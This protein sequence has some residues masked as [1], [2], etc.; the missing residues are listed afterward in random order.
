MTRPQRVTF[1][2]LIA[3]MLVAVASA[4]AGSPGTA[5]AATRSAS[6]VIDKS[7]TFQVR[8]VNRSALACP[9]DGAAYQVTGHLT[10][11][12]SKLG[13]QAA[14][15]TGSV[16]LYLHGA[17]F[18]E[19]FWRLSAV[20]RYDY[21][22]A[23]ARAGHVS[24][25]IDQLG[26]GSSGHP[27]GD[28]TCLGAA[29]DVAHQIVGKLRSGDYVLEGG[30]QSPR[31]EKVALAGHTAGALTANLEAFSFGDI[32]GLVAMSYTP[33]VTQQAFEQF[34]ASRAACQSGGEPASSGG[35]GGYAYF[36]QTAAEFQA[37]V[38]HSAE[39]EVTALATPLRSRD[40]CGDSASIVDAL[41]LDLKSLSRVK[42]PVLLVC[43]REDGMT[44]DFACP[45]L[46]KRY[47]GSS[48]AS[49]FFVRNAGDALP[50][51]RTAPTFRR[52]VSKWLNAH[53]F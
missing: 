43:G 15:G 17:S 38:F 47:V 48:D 30:G 34:Y 42:V 23:M 45:V 28:Q 6:G 25:V 20:P 27:Q 21:A 35:P 46:K 31:F 9:S 14:G 18:G 19:F 24:V 26:Y 16:T 7:V 49:L 22:A 11:P 8:N 41:V 50:L 1:R 4:A 32:D 2:I 39:P 44:P 51:E 5:N 12:A 36:G 53:G 13:K 37:R 29:A 10:G 33:Q 52:R 3:S 40:P